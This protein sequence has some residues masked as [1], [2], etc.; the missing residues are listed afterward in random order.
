MKFKLLYL[1]LALS[2]CNH[3]NE[4]KKET[5]PEDLPY[6]TKSYKPDSTNPSF[7]YHFENDT[8]FQSLKLQWL[9]AVTA[10]FEFSTY[11]KPTKTKLSIPGIA[12]DLHP[13][14]D[15][16]IEEDNEGNFIPMQE[17]IYAPSKTCGLSV[18][19]SLEDGR[20]SAVVSPYDC[21]PGNASAFYLSAGVLKKE[22]TPNQ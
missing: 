1:L 15:N 10:R 16:E 18:R 8:I 3:R 6:E 14:M 4:N 7:V 17:L 12:R 19:I 2:A 21:E 13:D 11:H 9:D 22:E 20:K 5:N